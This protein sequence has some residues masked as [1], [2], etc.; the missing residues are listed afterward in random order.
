MEIEI[1]S[2]VVCPFCYLG[3][4][5]FEKALEDFPGR[6]EANVTWKSFQLHPGLRAEPG[7]GL[8]RYLAER[9][10]WSLAQ[11]RANHDRLAQA[12]AELGL[13][14]RF[15]KAVIADTFDAHRLLQLARAEGKGSAMEERLFRAYFTEGVNLAD[16]SVLAR[17]AGEAGIDPGKAAAMLADKE[18]FADAVRAD[19]GEAENLGVNG[20]PFFVFDRRFAVSGAQ[21]TEVFKRALAQ[22]ASP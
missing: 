15:E 9:K 8:E 7:L 20:V 3:K 4:R 18:E 12:G 22:A 21:D 6:E 5:R 11:I 10:G 2:D 13:D 17:L 19:I 16:A 14:Y 1:W